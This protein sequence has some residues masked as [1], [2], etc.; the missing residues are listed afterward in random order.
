MIFFLNCQRWT[1][2]FRLIFQRLV[3]DYNRKKLQEAIYIEGVKVEKHTWCQPHVYW[4]GFG[5]QERDEPYQSLQS[6]GS[7]YHQARC[8]WPWC[9][10]GWCRCVNLHED[11]AT[12]SLPLWLCQASVSNLAALS[13]EILQSNNISRCY[14]QY[15]ES[16]RPLTWST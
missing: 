14:S 16:S 6:W 3:L 1:L 11:K 7:I 9:L 15:R 10:C 4:H 13:C 8:Y 5:P 2:T 12:P